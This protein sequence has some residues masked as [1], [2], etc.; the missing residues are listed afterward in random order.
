M[1]NGIS[2]IRAERGLMAKL[3]AG[4]GITKSAVSMWDKVPADRLAEVE[5]LS[6]IPR[7]LL[8]PDVC[9]PPDG[10]EVPHAARVAR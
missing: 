8:R 9:L 5:R 2:L 3:A 10:I 7:H 4:L 1:T 6:G